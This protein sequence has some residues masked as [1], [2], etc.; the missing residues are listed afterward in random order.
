MTRKQLFKKA[1]RLLVDRTVPYCWPEDKI[2]L[3][4]CHAIRNA[5]GLYDAVAEFE[6]LMKPA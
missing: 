1:A 6:S 5:G 4:C 3:F 2:T